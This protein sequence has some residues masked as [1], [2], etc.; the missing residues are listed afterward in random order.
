MR[1]SSI[2][3]ESHVLRQ[4]V[5]D[6]WRIPHGRSAFTGKRRLYGAYISG[7]DFVSIW[8]NEILGQEAMLH[9][10]IS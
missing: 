6:N 5:F 10:G 2:I 9:K 7:D 4:V 1:S 3:S 8:K